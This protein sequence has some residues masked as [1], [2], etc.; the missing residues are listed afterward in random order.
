MENNFNTPQ[1]P[2]KKPEP[3]GEKPCFS[4]LEVPTQELSEEEKELKTVNRK[5]NGIG[6]VLIIMFAIMQLWILPVVIIAQLI[7][8]PYDSVVNLLEN[9]YLNFGLH[10]V[11]S[12]FCFTVP[13]IVL[14][15][16]RKTTIS[17]LVP[18]G[19]AKKGTALP[20][21][22]FGISICSLA[23]I[24]TSYSTNFLNE[25]LSL[26]GLRYDFSSPD[27]EKG[28]LLFILAFLST[29]V[30]PGLV[31][32]FGC[33]GVMF[34]L[35]KEH[36]EGF[37]IIVTAVLFGVIHGNFVQI[38]FAFMVGLALAVIRLKT[39][40][41]W[42]AIAVHFCNNLVSVIFEYALYNLPVAL[43]DVLYYI[44]L[45]VCLL[46]GVLGVVLIAKNSPDTFSLN[47]NKNGISEKKLIRTALTRGT[48]ITIIVI[49]LL[50]SLAFISK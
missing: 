49:Y 31:E 22:F 15:K 20:F 40:T 36:S 39:G 14:A 27:G 34:G 9:E 1:N 26:F 3:I 30:V 19:P 6:L 11:L 29:A 28:I 35:L 16:V 33:R 10:V 50:L 47:F 38:P 5:M 41:L 4:P 45:M 32:E 43:Q 8:F 25:I 2:Y 42:V 23:N 18:L 13:F 48:I 7:G 37:A 21:F 12:S 44:Y 24:F 17:E 46:L